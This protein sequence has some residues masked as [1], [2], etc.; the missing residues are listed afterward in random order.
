MP[1]ARGRGTDEEQRRVW[2]SMLWRMFVGPAG[3]GWVGAGRPGIQGEGWW[4]EREDE[5]SR[6]QRAEGS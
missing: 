6:Y 4:G 1:L 3:L 2:F 5:K